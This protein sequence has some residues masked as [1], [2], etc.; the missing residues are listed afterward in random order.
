MGTV[1]DNSFFRK[2]GYGG[3]SPG[4]RACYISHYLVYKSIIDNGYRSA[5][6]LEDDVDFETDITEIMTGIHRNLPAYWDTLY[7]GH[8]YEQIGKLV[9]GSLANQ[10]YE[11]V[12]PSCTHA[13]AVSYWG[14]RKLVEKLDPMIP[15]GAIDLA[16]LAKIKNKELTSYSV[17]P[18]PIIQWKGRDNPSDVPESMNTYFSLKNSTLRFLGHKFV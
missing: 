18:M 12:M 2:Y 9:D 6:I 17:H 7:I 8:C 10:L 15:Q 16:L 13:Y 14:A 1:F 5:L 4:R 11:S 3:L